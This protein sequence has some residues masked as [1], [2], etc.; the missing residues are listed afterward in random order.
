[1]KTCVKRLSAVMLVLSLLA[2]CLLC[3]CNE[4][5]VKKEDVKLKTVMETKEYIKKNL[6]AANYVK[7]EEETDDKVVYIFMDKECGFRFRVTSEKV[8]KEME[9]VDLGYAEKTTDNWSKAYTEYIQDKLKEKADGLTESMGFKYEYYGFDSD[10]FMAVFTDK[11]AA[12]IEAS[13]KE[14]ADIIKAEDKYEK[15]QS[16]EIWCWNGEK[17]EAYNNLTGCYLLAENKIV[18]K[19]TRDELVKDKDSSSK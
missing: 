7:T 9:G 3:G 19:K 18:D 11:S 1:M 10:I 5:F 16:K 8:Q 15:F 2:V 14:L 12:D 6:P 13:V 4:T 17:D